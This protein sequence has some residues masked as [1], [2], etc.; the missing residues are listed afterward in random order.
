M[1]GVAE[2]AG[3]MLSRAFERAEVSAQN[4]SNLTTPGYKAVRWF[5]D[6]VSESSAGSATAHNRTASQ[7]DFTPGQLQ[8]TGAPFDLAISG[9]G[10]FVVRSDQQTFYTRDGQFSRGADGKLVT[11]GGLALQSSSGGDVVV[12]QNNPQIL[13]DGTVLESGQ[14]VARIG[15]VDF[16]DPGALQP[17]GSGLFTAAQSDETDANAQIH[18]GMLETSNVSTANEMIS[19]MAALRSAESGQKVVQVYDDLM[20]QAI[21]AFGQA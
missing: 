3:A 19:I 7:T 1:G 10:F 18:Q 16:S 9:S 14:P 8:N 4:L 13:S 15:V 11:A 20:A 17:Q 12:S 6:T 2:I 21:N 5:G